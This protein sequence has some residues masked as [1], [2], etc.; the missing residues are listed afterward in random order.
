MDKSYG[1]CLWLGGVLLAGLRMEEKVISE[2]P[3]ALSGGWMHETS[4][5]FSIPA[6]TISF[7]LQSRPVVLIFPFS[8]HQAWH[9]IRQCRDVPDVDLMGLFAISKQNGLFISLFLA[10]CG[11]KRENPSADPL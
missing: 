5:H 11:Q 7:V 9:A 3:S 1:V 6:Y 4:L 2:Q 8:Y 10:D